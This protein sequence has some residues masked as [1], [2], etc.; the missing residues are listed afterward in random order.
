MTDGFTKLFNSIITSSIWSETDKV[1]IMWITFLA[2]SDANGFVTGSIPGMAAMARMSLQEAEQSIKSLTKPDP[3]SRTKEQEGRRLLECEGGWIIV[4]YAKYRKRQVHEVASLTTKGY[5]YYVEAN[6]RIKIGFSKNPWSRIHD[7]RVSVPKAK[8]LA[9][10]AGT[11]ELE[12]K[13]HA[14]FKTDRIEGEWFKPSKSLLW[15]IKSIVGDSVAT[16]VATGSDYEEA[17]AEADKRYSQNST[18]FRLASL[19]LSEIQNRKPDYKKPNLQKWTVHIDRMIRLDKRKPGRIESVIRWCQQ[20]APKGNSNFGWQDNILS[21]AKLREKF[22]KLELAMQRK[23][24]QYTKP[25]ERGPAGLT[26]R[27]ELKA[28]FEKGKNDGTEQ[29]G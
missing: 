21:T 20:D 17:E 3:Y 28:R 19:L 7:L 10:E 6:K 4:N 23:A 27:E 29:G 5:V 14:Q 11:L 25:M 24:R 22:D 8:L 16:T 18:E 12:N 26:P 1:R 13:R 2:S 15:H 9:S